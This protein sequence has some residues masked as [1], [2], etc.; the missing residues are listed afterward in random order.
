MLGYKGRFL[1]LCIFLSGCATYQSKVE[2]ARTLLESHDAEKAIGLL[3]PLAKED[4]KDQLIYIFD[5]ATALQIAGK[6]KESNQELMAADRMSDRKNYLS[7][8]R[9]GGSLL[10]NEEMTQYKGE[11]YER[12][13]INVMSAINYLM[14]RDRENALVEVRRLNEK[15]QY[16]RLEE[17]KE[18]EQNTA[19]LYLSALLWEAEKNW[20]SAYIDFERTYKRD[21]NISYIQEDLVRSAIHAGRGDAAKKWS[22]EFSLGPKPEW[23]DKDIGELVLI[24]QQGWGPRKAERPRVVTPYGFV[25]PGF[26]M[27]Q[28]TRTFTRRAKVEVVSEETV[29]VLSVE[30]TKTIYN[31]QDTSIKTLE[32]S[33]GPLIAK[34]IAAFIAKKVAANAIDK[35]NEGLGAVLFFATQIADRADLRQWSTLPETIQVAKLQLKAGKYKVH[36]RVLF[37]SGQYSGE[38]MPPIEVEIKPR[39]KTFLN[40]R[41]FR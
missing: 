11:D 18:Y 34:R 20:D 30:E 38:D 2:R 26:P 12:L 23:R 28:P 4:G 37:E 13:L 21:S 25:S 5:Y 1:F 31:V 17:K 24:Y 33:Y 39:D 9:F 32:D 6:Y 29:P 16:Y 19:A 10:F 36:I 14:L 41:S 15:L 40:W 22:K 27:L 3:K 8:S 7:V 35:K